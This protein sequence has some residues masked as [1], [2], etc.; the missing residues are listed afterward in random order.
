MT[1]RRRLF[2]VFFGFAVLPI[3][4]IGA[5][6]ILGVFRLA[7]KQA[8]E[9]LRGYL[10]LYAGLIDQELEGERNYLGALLEDVTNPYPPAPGARPSDWFRTQPRLRARL[11]QVPLLTS[12]FLFLEEGPGPALALEGQWTPGAVSSR[13]FQV[14]P[15]SV[16]EFYRRLFGEAPSLLTDLR[17]TGAV[18]ALTL[19][20]PGTATRPRG[21]LVEEIAVIVLLDH[22]LARL[23]FPALETTFAAT[24][25]GGPGAWIYL[26]HSDP[27]RIGLPADPGE[28]PFGE[29][30]IGAVPKAGR[31]HGPW[32]FLRKGDRLFA[33]ARHAS[34]GWILGGSMT[35]SGMLS[36]LR[37]NVRISAL[38]LGLMI[39][40]VSAGIVLVTR[41]IGG[42]VEEIAAS[43]GAIA[44]GDLYRTIRLHRSDEFGAIAEHVNAMARDLIVTSEARSIARISA[45]LVHD[46]KG[47]A[48]QIH[49]MLYN[50]KENYDDPE[51]RAES[52]PLLQDLARQIESLA[53]RL[54]R[55]RESGE[56]TWEE[57]DLGR[58]VGKIL[59]SR[60]RPSWPGI[61]VREDLRCDTPA[62]ANEDLLSEAVENI[63][64]NA[65]EA[66]GGK[67][68]LRV[69]VGA[70]PA[71]RREDPN[72]STH[73]I[74]VEDTGPGMSREFI[75]NQLFQPFTTTKEKGLGL[76]MYQVR[77]AVLRLA[78]R[79]E[80]TSR[81]GHGTRVRLEVGRAREGGP[82]R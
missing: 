29:G 20:V 42:A 15:E 4:A 7:G 38:L 69:C 54:R 68:T 48:S 33:S 19:P 27:T 24:P 35:L 51:F 18:M 72:G 73:F 70:L 65:A 63:A 17:P 74:E 21:L 79:I 3:A 60:V 61:V 37:E 10:D 22:L 44:R 9:E 25:G 14:P 40:L 59:E 52:V 58:L 45:R 41:G 34:T 80:V 8:L 64:S 71:P 6:A 67:G 2:L 36:P 66:M 62:I 56:P 31:S 75:D 77:Q 82:P 50:L 13:D 28:W 78:G 53:L 30:L 5:A 76:G 47:I 55:G 43:A 32:S 57:V 26:H 23:P 16:P 39:L 1:L 49:L 81:P 46:L 11:G 12:R